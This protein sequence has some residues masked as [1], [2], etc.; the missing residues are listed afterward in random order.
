MSTGEDMC[1]DVAKNVIESLNEA[2]DELDRYNEDPD[3]FTEE[4][5]DE[6]ISSYEIGI[7]GYLDS[8]LKDLSTLRV[9]VDT[10]DIRSPRGFTLL[11]GWGGP[12]IWLSGD[13]DKVWVEVYW[14]CDQYKEEITSSDSELYDEIWTWL[15]DAWEWTLEMTE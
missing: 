5:G 3:K 9:E 14:G 6:Y 13:L 1:K 8:K 11:L 2:M 10:S 15:V 7:Y 4:R 12:N